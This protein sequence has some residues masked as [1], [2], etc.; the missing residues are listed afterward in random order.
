MMRILTWVHGDDGRWVPELRSLSLS[1]SHKVDGHVGGLVPDDV[2]GVSQLQRHRDVVR[3]LQFLP[4]WTRWRKLSISDPISFVLVDYNHSKALHVRELARELIDHEAWGE[5]SLG[6]QREQEP[7]AVQDGRARNLQQRRVRV[8]GDS[9][10]LLLRQQQEGFVIGVQPWQSSR[11][12]EP[13]LAACGGLQPGVQQPTGAVV[14]VGTGVSKEHG[15][16]LVRL[17]RPETIL[18][19]EPH[20]EDLIGLQLDLLRMCTFNGDRSL[21]P[22]ARDDEFERASLGDIY[23]DLLG[24]PGDCGSWWDQV[25]GAQ[26]LSGEDEGG[27]HAVVFP[28]DGLDSDAFVAGDAEEPLRGLVLPQLHYFILKDIPGLSSVQGLL[29]RYERVQCK[30]DLRAIVQGSDLD[31]VLRVMWKIVGDVLRENHY[32]VQTG[33]VLW[34]CSRFWRRKVVFFYPMCDTSV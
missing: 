26:L 10:G 32:E 6:D 16:R 7:G 5:F 15:H 17:H 14:P 21:W 23:R 24:G 20:H 11:N 2:L 27:L 29:F 19:M 12:K 1:L 4:V 30:G 8:K 22:G 28:A 34:S 18:F 31:L 33:A 13:E 9:P 3:P 25:L